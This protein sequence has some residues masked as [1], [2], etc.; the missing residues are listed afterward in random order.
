M[1]LLKIIILAFLLYWI[2]AVERDRKHSGEG[3]AV[4]RYQN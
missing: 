1:H 2:V 3:A 4:V